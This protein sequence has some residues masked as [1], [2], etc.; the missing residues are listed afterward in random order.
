VASQG[1]LWT[2][3]AERLVSPK[4]DEGGSGDS[5]LAWLVNRVG[6]QKA[7]L[8]I[9]KRR[10]TLFASVAIPPLKIDGMGIGR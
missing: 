1:P 7:A 5:A 3:L 10:Q 8:R 4:S 9:P 2:A 6:L